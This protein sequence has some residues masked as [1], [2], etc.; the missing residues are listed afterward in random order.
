MI[1]CIV[2]SALVGATAV[3]TQGM[4]RHQ[5]ESKGFVKAIEFK[6]QLRVCN[7]YAFAGKLDIFRGKGEKLTSDGAMPYKTCKDFVAPLKAGDKLDFKIGESSAGSFSVSELPNNDAVLLLVVQRHDSVSTAVSFESHVFA[8]VPNAQVAV[9]DAYK[10]AK[11]DMPRIMDAKPAGKA[12][13]GSRTEDLRYDSVV[14]VSPGVYEVSLGNEKDTHGA[15]SSLVALDRQS[16]V[17]LR[18]G[19]EGKVEGDYPEDLLVFPQ[20]D[21]HALPSGA[22]VTV[23]PASALFLSLFAFVTSM[24]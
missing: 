12:A 2:I 15:H 18:I 17:V 9:I 5:V 10:G 7:A 6:H 20:S 11:H 22:V 3:S 24:M 19:N 23:L 8:N 14:A 16:Y 21:A 1:A 13:K 4:L